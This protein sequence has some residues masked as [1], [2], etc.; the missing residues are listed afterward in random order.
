MTG[1]K[2]NQISG[3]NG[4]VPPNLNRENLEE[5]LD[6]FKQLFLIKSVKMNKFNKNCFPPQCEPP[7]AILCFSVVLKHFWEKSLKITFLDKKVTISE[8]SSEIHRKIT[9]LNKFQEEKI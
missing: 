2:N 5:N 9:F 3:K 7:T 6:L 1:T 4:I 8:R